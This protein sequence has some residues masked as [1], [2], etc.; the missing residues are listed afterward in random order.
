M[1]KLICSIAWLILAV[2]AFA[3]DYVIKTVQVLPIDSYPSRQTVGAVTIAADPYATNEKSYTA[4]D[5]KDLNSRG[6]FPLH[7]IIQNSSPNFVTIHVRNIQLKTAGGEQLYTTSATI[8]VQD[9][10]KAGFV[11][12]LPKMKSHDQTIS[13]KTGSPLLD[14]TGKEL[15]NRQIDPGSVSDGFLF[16][17]TTEPKKNLFAGST[18]MIPELI[19]EGS[20]R[21]VGSFSIPLGSATTAS[22]K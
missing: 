1:R 2:A 21:P 14:F 15:T 5:V 17:Y 7:V 13:T 22:G 11:S 8:V 9:V 3:A 19:D 10:I 6:Y 4:F 20:H 16:F 18:L 12:R